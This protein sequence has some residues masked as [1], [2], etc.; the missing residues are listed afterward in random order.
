MPDTTNDRMAMVESQLKA[1]GIVDPRVLEAMAWVPRENFLPDDRRAWAYRDRAVP[2]GLGQT[3]SQPYMVAA[4]TQALRLGPED[5][6]LEVGTG[7]G[8]QTAVL[9][10]IASE[11]F[12]MERL[13]ALQCA[14][15]ERLSALG[16]SNVHLR[17]GDGSLGWREKAPF[18]AII[19]TAGAPSVPPALKEQLSEEG[20]RL[21]I[22]VGPR[23]QQSL[24]RYTHQGNEY[25]SERLLNCSFVPLVGSEGWPG[26]SDYDL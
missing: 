2:L 4:M 19:V 8:Y 23:T 12:S 24:L 3:V 13:R 21:V 17:I 22:P 6:V 25:V 5:R 11:V 1:R 15:E 10:T 7:S 14:A 16:I 9:S 20:G 18:D 26:D